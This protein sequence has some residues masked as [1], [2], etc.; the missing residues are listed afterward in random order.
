MSQEAKILTAIGIVT[1]VVV[2]GAA[3]I[4]GGSTSADKPNPKISADQMKLIVRED[5]HV[6]GTKDAKITL[7]EFGD[8]QCPSCAAS[9]PIVSQLL[10]EYKGKVTFV[11]R[12][13]PLAMHTNAKI[14]A[15]AAE[16][17]GAQ[18]KFFEMYD[19]LFQN[20]QEWGESKNPLEHFQKYA[21]MIG[22]DTDKFTEE[23]KANK[24]KSKIEKDVSDGNALGVS[25][26]PSFFLNGEKIT[27]GL[28]YDKFKEKFEAILSGS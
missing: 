24:Y 26:T 9:H 8:F 27:G 19:A 17:A 13:Y 18:G 21:D 3:F 23:V 2:V 14:A 5:S 28:P 11:F 12:N 7:V 16:A 4:F 6:L 10:T 1:L 15:E 22:L 20:Q 25:A